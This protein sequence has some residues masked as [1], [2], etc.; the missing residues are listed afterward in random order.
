[1]DLAV[2][3]QAA[4]VLTL[5]QTSVALVTVLQAVWLVL[6]VTALAQMAALVQLAAKA[7][8]AVQVVA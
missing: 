6:A 5:E 1:M 2:I 3:P 7:Q 4:T 8:A